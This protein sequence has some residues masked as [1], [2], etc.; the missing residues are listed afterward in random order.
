MHAVLAGDVTLM[1]SLSKATSLVITSLLNPGVLLL[2]GQFK[3]IWPE[4]PKSGRGWGSAGTGNWL[5][6]C[7]YQQTHAE[8]TVQVT[9]VKLVYRYWIY[10]LFRFGSKMLHHLL[11]Y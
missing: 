9:E 3:A 8:K 4:Q 2:Q 10:C 5:Q 6:G 1:E 11:S 7:K